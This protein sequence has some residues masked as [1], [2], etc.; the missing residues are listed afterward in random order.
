MIPTICHARTQTADGLWATKMGG[1]FEEGDPSITPFH[2]EGTA[3]IKELGGHLRIFFRKVIIVRRLFATT[4]AL[5]ASLLRD[6]QDQKKKSKR[7][8]WV[9][10][11][12]PEEGEDPTVA[13][14]H[15]LSDSDDD[16]DEDEMEEKETKILEVLIEAEKRKPLVLPK[17]SLFLTSRKPKQ[18]ITPL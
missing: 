2:L 18:V 11:N 5:K 8:K 7:E 13:A 15:E 14:Q 4:D 10:E 16:L 3:D 9:K 17:L 1:V 6:F 12:P